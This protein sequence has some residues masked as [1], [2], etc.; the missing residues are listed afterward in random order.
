MFLRIN[1][2]LS[3]DNLSDSP[4][5]VVDQLRELLG[6]G[7]EARLDPKRRNFYEVEKSGQV[8]YI[9]S[10]PLSGKVMLL[11]TWPVALPLAECVAGM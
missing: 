5:E 9:H 8:F 1:E 11:A 2:Q 3:I 7:A 10:A 4:T 6:S